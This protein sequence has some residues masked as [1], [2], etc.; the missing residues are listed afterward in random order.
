MGAGNTKTDDSLCAKYFDQEEREKITQLFF[1]I[2]KGNETFTKEQYKE[3]IKN[4][5]HDDVAHNFYEHVLCSTTIC[6]S[7]DKVPP[8]YT[9][10]VS[11]SKF[12][13]SLATLLKGSVEEKGK[14]IIALCKMKVPPKTPVT[15]TN[16]QSVELLTL[17]QLVE[18]LVES[19]WMQMS[20]L[21]LTH[22]HWNLTTN[23][24]AIRRL[25]TTL[26]EDLPVTESQ[27]EG[28]SGKQKV[29]QME[30][31]IWLLKASLFTRIFDAVFYKCF[32]LTSDVD[33]YRAGACFPLERPL[34]S[35]PLATGVNWN[36]MS[37]LLDYPALV[38]LTHHLPKEFRQAWMLLFSGC[39]HGNSFSQLMTH[40]V[41]KG[42][43]LIIVQDKDKYCFGGIAASSWQLKPTFY[44]TTGCR[45]F[46]LRPRLSI[47]S[48]SGYN[49]HFMYLNHGQQTLPNGLGMGG[50][51][52][53]FGL[54]IDDSFNT[55]HSKAAP[56][57]TT[58][59]SPQLSALPEFEVDTIEVWSIQPQATE[60]PEGTRSILDQNVEAKAILDMIGKERRSEGFRELD[61]D[62][63]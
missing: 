13:D 2:T 26:L 27:P 11:H 29:T 45:L 28:L 55:G 44:G 51:F 16:T 43:S 12:G 59:N 39:V 56:T 60:N 25:A 41:K 20:R 34:I 36:K 50:Q 9:V 3:Y 23:Q 57:S 49:D 19:L 61:P 46:T 15:L 5:V 31:E 58:Y 4:K 53:Y 52:N 18:Q 6:P 32:N 40:I 63:L 17:Q 54:W 8:Q 38:Y 30:V 33:S 48:P 24:D 37:T 42:P 22:Y 10:T 21:V 35:L 1:K 7:Q 14:A 62:I 47:Y